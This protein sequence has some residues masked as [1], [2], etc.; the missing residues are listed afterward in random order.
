MRFDLTTYQSRLSRLRSILLSN[1]IQ[2]LILFDCYNIRYLTGFTG[3]D[4][5]LIVRSQS[6]TLLV[7]GRYLTQA[8][9]EVKIADIHLYQDKVD[10]IEEVLDLKAGETIGFEASRQL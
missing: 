5:T 8:R 4:G 3:S 2:H 1:E 6:A 10:G 7:D 9:E